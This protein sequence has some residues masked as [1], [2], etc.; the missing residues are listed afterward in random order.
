MFTVS[1]PKLAVGETRMLDKKTQQPLREQ[2]V[3]IQHP[4]Q[5]HAVET[6]LI[7]EPGQEPYPVGQYEIAADSIKAGE[8]GRAE[9][10]LKMGKRI[11]AKK[12]SAAA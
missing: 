10:R 6:S 4:E 12:L 1:I 9:F 11:E 2:K 5:F 8:Y 7:L 3:L